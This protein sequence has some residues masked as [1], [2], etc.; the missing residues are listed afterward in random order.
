MRSRQSARYDGVNVTCVWLALVTLQLTIVSGSDEPLP[1]GS[2]LRVE[3]RDTSFAD[4]P[5]VV[6]KKIDKTV[7]KTGRTTSVSVSMDVGSVGDGF[8]AW[9]HID[10]DGDGRVSRGDLISVESYPV[11]PATRQLTLRLKRVS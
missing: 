7:K 9:A 11:T 4:A 3:L 1:P 8:T 5:A 6:V 2:R 10:V